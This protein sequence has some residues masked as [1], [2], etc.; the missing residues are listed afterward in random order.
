MK[1]MIEISPSALSTWN[2]CHRKFGF[3]YISKIPAPSGRGAE[4]GTAIHKQIEQYMAGDALDFQAN[5]QAAEVAAGFIPHLPPS[6]VSEEKFKF[7]F[8]H[9]DEHPVW[10]TGRIDFYHYEPQF[11][12]VLVGDFKSTKSIAK[13]AKTPEQL[14][15]DPQAV[16]YSKQGLLKFADAESVRLRW[17]YGQTQ[18][19]KRVLPVEHHFTPRE[20]DDRMYEILPDARQMVY[21]R[22]VGTDPNELEPNYDACGNFGGCPYQNVC[23]RDLKGIIMSQ[24]NAFADALKKI[25]QTVPSNFTSQAVNPPEGDLPPA[26][27]P[28]KVDTIPA[29][30]PVEEKSSEKAAWLAK[31]AAKKAKKPEDA[32]RESFAQGNLAI[33]R[34]AG[35]R[36]TEVPQTDAR[37]FITPTGT[38]HIET[39]YIDCHP[40]RAEVTYATDIFAEARDRIRKETGLEHWQFIDYKAAAALSVSVEDAVKA[41]GLIA[42]LVVDS[43]TAEGR[44]VLEILRNL[45]VSIVRGTR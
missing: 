20:V 4:L 19:A 38:K 32:Q 29:P 33:D 1:T 45:S 31:K 27:D 16:I 41:K 7:L 18:G 44:A 42:K 40:E 28:K 15:R 39:L 26:L 23:K 35:A 8:P 17:L 11:R 34:D 14:D 3:K 30:P 36:R 9:G 2:E 5:P 21:L 22:T 12:V 10:F 24:S 37:Q 6:T 13:Y 25:G 43:Q